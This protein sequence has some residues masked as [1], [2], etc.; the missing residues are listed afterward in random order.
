MC[1]RKGQTCLRFTTFISLNYRTDEPNQ[2][3]NEFCFFRR[4]KIFS[5]LSFPTYL[6]KLCA[7]ACL[8]G[9][10]QVMTSHLL[11]AD[12]SGHKSHLESTTSISYISFLDIKRVCAVYMHRCW[13][14]RGGH[15]A[16]DGPQMS[17]VGGR[18]PNLSYFFLGFV[19]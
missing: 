12:Y 18:P 19:N 3:K 5:S 10:Q 6:A 9:N 4:S 13:T 2:T 8:S 1:H 17:T 14:H 16:V 15:T 11:V 7:T